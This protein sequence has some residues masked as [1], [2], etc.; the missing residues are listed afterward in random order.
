[1]RR[2]AVDGCPSWV[3]GRIP[4]LRLGVHPGSSSGQEPELVLAPPCR[5][6]TESWRLRGTYMGCVGALTAHSPL[7][8]PVPLK[9]VGQGEQAMPSGV[10]V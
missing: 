9:G 3:E 5:A 7:T 2:Q 1:M 8:F 4:L 10:P 6:V